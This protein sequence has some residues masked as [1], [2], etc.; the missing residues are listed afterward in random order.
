MEDTANIMKTKKGLILS[1]LKVFAIFELRLLSDKE[2]LDVTSIGCIN[3]KRETVLFL[4]N[5]TFEEIVTK[6]VLNSI[7]HHVGMSWTISSN[8]EMKYEMD[9][10]NHQY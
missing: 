5:T 7:L 9:K 8:D 6:F 3:C 1:L 10:N 4:K 2:K